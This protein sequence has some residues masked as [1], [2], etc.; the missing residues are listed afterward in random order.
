MNN[1]GRTRVSF[2][3]SG[4]CVGQVLARVHARR[5]RVYA[6][7]R[8]FS[9]AGKLHDDMKKG[10]EDDTP[11]STRFLPP[12]TRSEARRGEGRVGREG[13]EG[14]EGASSQGS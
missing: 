6:V 1:W 10:Q 2:H 4:S 11:S 9:K 5:H 7:E 14:A 8:M 13:G 3:V 12:P